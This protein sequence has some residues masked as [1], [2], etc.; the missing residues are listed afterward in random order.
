[1][2]RRTQSKP[3]PVARVEGE[4]GTY[5][6]GV[7]EPAAAQQRPWHPTVEEQTARADSACEEQD[8]VDARRKCSVDERAEAAAG[9]PLEVGKHAVGPCMHRLRV[10]ADGA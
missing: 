1:V 3:E 8:H 2:G 9:D 4:R 7:R 6:G 5:G 10:H